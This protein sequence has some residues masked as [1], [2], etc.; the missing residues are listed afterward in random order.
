MHRQR[1]VPRRGEDRRDHVDLDA[2]AEDEERVPFSH[3]LQAA[4]STRLGTAYRESR[5]VLHGDIEGALRL[6]R[7]GRLVVELHR[8][9]LRTR[10]ARE[11]RGHACDGAHKAHASLGHWGRC[12]ARG[13]QHGALRWTGRWRPRG[14]RRARRREE[15]P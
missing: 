2:D 1:R 6:W 9:A 13:Q 5:V 11:A 7:S 3:R 12:R 4:P 8:V 14:W 10:L 15:V